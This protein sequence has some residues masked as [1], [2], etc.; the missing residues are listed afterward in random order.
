VEKFPFDLY[1]GVA[2]PAV[3]FARGPPVYELCFGDGEGITQAGCVVLH[4]L[5]KLLEAADVA[6][7]RKE[8]Y[9][10]SVVMHIRDH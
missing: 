6:S 9:S 7:V 5:E 2:L 1:E 4:L 8:G 3:P 10:D